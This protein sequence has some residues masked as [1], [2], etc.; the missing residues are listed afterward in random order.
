[1][2]DFTSDCYI[3]IGERA[4]SVTAKVIA[5]EKVGCAV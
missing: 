3:K 5:G 4:E 1:M 2:I